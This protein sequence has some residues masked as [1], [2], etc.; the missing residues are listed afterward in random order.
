MA[1]Q[2]GFDGV[3]LGVSSQN[4]HLQVEES[5]E[6]R[7]AVRTVSLTWIVHMSTA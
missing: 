7:A 4:T 2:E 5:L 3:E 6:L 1:G